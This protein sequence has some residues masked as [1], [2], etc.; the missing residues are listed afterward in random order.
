MSRFDEVE[1]FH[2]G[3]L[4]PGKAIAVPPSIAEV[5]RLAAI[6]YEP[7]R[8]SRFGRFRMEHEFKTRPRVFVG[9]GGRGIFV[10][11]GAFTRR[12]FVN[13]AGKRTPR[14]LLRDVKA[15][16]A[17]YARHAVQWGENTEGALNARVRWDDLR[18]VYEAQKARA[19]NP[20]RNRAGYR[21]DRL[22]G[23]GRFD[24]RSFR[25]IE[26]PGGG[27]AVVGC[28]R[29][30][31]DARRRCC[32]VGMERQALLR[33]LDSAP[34]KR[35]NLRADR[36]SARNPS[37]LV[38]AENPRGET[39]RRRR[40]S[41]GRFLSSRSARRKKRGRARGARRR[42][43]RQ[44]VENPTMRR[45]RRSP[46]GR[47]KS[48]RRRRGRNPAGFSLA[49]L[50]IIPRAETVGMALSGAGGF[51]ATRIL[52]KLVL[53]AR[54][55]GIVGYLG[56]FV[57]SGIAASVLGMVFGRRFVRPA[58]IGGA[59]ATGVRILRTE[60][61]SREGAPA[62]LKAGLD[63]LGELETDDDLDD[64]EL[65]DYELGNP[66]RFMVPRTVGTP[67][68]MAASSR[69]PSKYGA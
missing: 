20:S 66:K 41:R 22:E 14:V 57:A 53:G 54:D 12:G 48:S 42:S 28:P 44:P 38:L 59:I 61:A 34:S 30:K 10:P 17:D 27:R 55:T 26:L 9:E 4:R 19:R 7:P 47:Q 56:N 68:A 52:T 13:P 49:G 35:D 69:F 65:S 37:L 5:G 60:V 67:A 39:M 18:A 21:H 32:R 23:P 31:W 63:D 16:E 36:T 29:G 1:K 11:E 15:A 62:W 51:A 3:A 43:R 58:A 50:Q 40:D 2:G 64:Y 6:H 25:T 24:P 33:A 46:P 45:A 8:G